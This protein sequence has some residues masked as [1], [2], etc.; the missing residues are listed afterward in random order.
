[1]K[2]NSVYKMIGDGMPLLVIVAQVL[3][4]IFWIS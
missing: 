2:N 4:L 1:M 3:G